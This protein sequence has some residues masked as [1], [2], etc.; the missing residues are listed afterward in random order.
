MTS[1]N[2]T[3]PEPFV[4]LHTVDSPDEAISAQI[5]LLQPFLKQ[6]S[7]TEYSLLDDAELATR[8]RKGL[9]RP[10]VP[11][12]G[13]IPQRRRAPANSSQASKKQKIGQ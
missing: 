9:T 7:T 1:S 3:A 12:S 5:G 2:F 8:L 11:A 6:R 4:S 10:K 13:K